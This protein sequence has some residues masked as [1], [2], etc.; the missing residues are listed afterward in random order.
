MLDG[1]AVGLAQY[2]HRIGYMECAFYGVVHPDNADYACR[3][4]WTEAQ[5]DDMAAYLAHAQELIEEELGYPLVP[6][7]ITNEP[8][9][10]RT[11]VQSRWGHVISGGVKSETVIQDG[12]AVNDAADPAVVTVNGVTCAEENVHVYFAGTDE[13]IEPTDVSITAGVL[14]ITIPWCR[15]VAPAYRNQTDEGLAYADAATWTA[16]TVDVHCIVNDTSTQAHLLALPSA[17]CTTT[18]CSATEY[19]AC[20]LVRMPEIGSLGVQRADYADG[21]WTRKA[22]CYS[23]S[24]MSLNYYAGLLELPRGAEDAIIRLAHALMADEPCGCDVTQ[25]LWRRDRNVPAMLTRERINNPWGIN[26]GSW[27]AW[28]WTQARKLRRG[29]VL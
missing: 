20:I 10:Y 28:M 6:R 15:L 9:L 14:T 5:R 22:F 17:C 19:D 13:E 27:Y 26:D 18:P 23:P 25:R 7:W 8:H 12:A 3:A 1:I 2:A 21:A 11:P 24:T 16:Q 29:A 4:I